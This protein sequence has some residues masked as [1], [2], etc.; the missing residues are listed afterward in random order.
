MGL[1]V[2]L[3]FE[4][5]FNGQLKGPRG[6]VTIG[7]KPDTMA[8]YDLLFG[9]L[10][11]CFYATFLSVADKKRIKFESADIEVTG[12]KRDETPTILKWVTVKL[13]IKGAEKEK[14]LVKAAEL[15]AEYCS[16]YYTLAQVAEMNLEVVFVD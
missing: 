6:E 13:T 7:S 2:D 5:G 3:H 10:A 16:I 9:A 11:S 4:D 14:G 8:P 15:G 12:E 1:K